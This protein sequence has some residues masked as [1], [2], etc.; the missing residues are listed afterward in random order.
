MTKDGK[1]YG[2]GD[3]ESGKIG[4]VFRG[5]SHDNRYNLAMQMLSVGARQAVDIFCGSHTSFYKN[6]K[7]QLFAF[8]L[9]NH[10]QLGIGSLGETNIATL[11]TFP[12][13]PVDII[14][15]TGGE[16]HTIALTKDGHVYCWGRN[17]ESQCGA[18]DLY[19]PYRRKLKEEKAAAEEAAAKAL[20]DAKQ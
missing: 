18:G 12:E 9:N 15:V 8:G 13:G 2:W 6:K 14:D 20:E 11:V 3:A 7:G 17:D 16:H 19:L 1:V 4:R 5:R 10:G